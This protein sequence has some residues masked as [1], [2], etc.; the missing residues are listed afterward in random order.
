MRDLQK[1]TV[2][3]IERFR[4]LGYTVR[5]LWECEFHQQLATNPEIKDFVRNLNLDTPLEPRYGFLGGHTNAV[6]LYKEVADEEKIHYVDFTFLYPWTNKYC[7]VPLGHPESLTSKALVN[8]SIDDFF[9]TIKCDILPPSFLFHPLTGNSCFR[10]AEPVQRIS[11]KRLVNTA[12]A[13]TP[14]LEHGCPLKSKRLVNSVI[15]W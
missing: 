9:G 8:H 3:K 5:V 13:N 4:K 7:E 1:G 12:T 2:R 10:Y 11:N 6:S 15:V 14:S